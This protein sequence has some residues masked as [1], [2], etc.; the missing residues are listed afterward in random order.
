MDLNAT[1]GT[2]ITVFK[3]LDD[4]ALTNWKTRKITLL[5]Y[6]VRCFEC[7]WEK[8]GVRGRIEMNT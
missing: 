7:V 1:F 5:L 2:V 8:M 6:C 4:T 3:V